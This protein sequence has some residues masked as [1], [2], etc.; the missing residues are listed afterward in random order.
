MVLGEGPVRKPVKSSSKSKTK[1]RAAPSKRVAATKAAK[2]AKTKPAKA[3]PVKTK[4]SAKA[5]PAKKTAAVAPDAKGCCIIKYTNGS[6]EAR[7]G[8]TRQQCHD[9]EISSQAVAAT[10]WQIGVCA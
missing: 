1:S 2:P 10:H 7:N 9:I 5:K 6:E 3:K 4:K 8:L